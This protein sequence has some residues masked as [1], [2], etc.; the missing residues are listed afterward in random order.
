MGYGIEGRTTAIAFILDKY[1]AGIVVLKQDSNGNFNPIKT[2]ENIQNGV[3]TYTPKP[4]N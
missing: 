2:E 4:C 1:N 3:K